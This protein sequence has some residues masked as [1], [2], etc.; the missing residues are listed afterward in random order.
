[1]TLKDDYVLHI[2]GHAGSYVPYLPPDVPTCALTGLHVTALPPGRV[3]AVGR[4]MPAFI[5]VVP[6]PV[7]QCDGFHF[8]LDGSPAERRSI[9]TSG[10]GY[11]LFAEGQ[12]HD[13]RCTNTTWE[14]FLELDQSRLPALAAEAWD[15]RAAI[16]RPMVTRRDPEAALLGR[17]TIDHLRSGDP[18]LLFVQGLAIAIVAK[19]LA[20]DGKMPTVACR[21]T[22]GR[23]ARA[24]DYIEAYL[25]EPLSVAQVASAAAMSPSWF[26]AAFKSV[27]GQPVFAYVRERRLERA[28]ILLADRRLSLS[29]IAFDCGFSSHSHMTRLFIKRYGASPKAMRG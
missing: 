9:S 12:T 15:G 14:L 24:I 25:G 7:S 5:N 20:S 18:D 23:I 21:G 22:D 28:R 8:L 4:D 16:D 2:P 10:G 3:E 19:A 13:I 6:E 27:T 11:D 29:Q 1:M 26:R 17:L